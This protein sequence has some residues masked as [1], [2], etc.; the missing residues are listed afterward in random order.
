MVQDEREKK[1]DVIAVVSAF[2]DISLIYRLPWNSPRIDEVKGDVQIHSWYHK[3]T[4]SSLSAEA[5]LRLAIDQRMKTTQ[6]RLSSCSY[7]NIIIVSLGPALSRRVPIS[8][9]VVFSPSYHHTCNVF[10]RV[11][12]TTPRPE[13]SDRL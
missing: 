9:R 4:F 3:N 13:N 12:I 7:V 6:G 2:L 10:Y 11:S 5:S 8:P 1:G